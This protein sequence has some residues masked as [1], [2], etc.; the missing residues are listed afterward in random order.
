MKTGKKGEHARIA[1]VQYNAKTKLQLKKTLEK[2]KSSPRVSTRSTAKKQADDFIIE[3]GS[4]LDALKE[5]FTAST[6]RVSDLIENFNKTD[7]RI[8]K[9]VQVVD[10]MGKQIVLWGERIR[11]INQRMTELGQEHSDPRPET[12]AS[13]KS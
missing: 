6:E 7:D 4:E 10:E 13:Q 12:L 9:L 2:N 8:L 11:E 5:S 3:F 1:N